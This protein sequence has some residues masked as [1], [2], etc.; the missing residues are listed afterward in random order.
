MKNEGGYDPDKN[1]WSYFM[2]YLNLLADIC[3]QRNMDPLRYI[4]K[5][6]QL[7]T[8][9]AFLH[10]ATVKKNLLF[11]PFIRLV[12]HAFVETSS[13]EEINRITKVKQWDLLGDF[14]IPKAKNSIPEDLRKTM[15]LIFNYIRRINRLPFSSK[16]TP[17]DS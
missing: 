4:E 6:L 3:V 15:D 1:H 10:E 2:Q 13:Y 11:Q 16:K 7:K 9:V 17:E 8:L 12:H 14:N 5:N